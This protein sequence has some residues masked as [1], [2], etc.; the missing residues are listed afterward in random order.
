MRKH[1]ALFFLLLILITCTSCRAQTE[2]NTL[3]AFTMR[4]NQLSTT[5]TLSENGYI[6]DQK[7]GT[8]SRF[9]KFS[10]NEFLLQFAVDD[11][12]SLIEMSIVYTHTLSESTTEAEFIKN[13]ISAFINDPETES[14]LFKEKSLWD[15]LNATSLETTEIKSG[16]TQLLLDVTEYGTVITV[17]KNSPQA[18]EQEA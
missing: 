17:V 12:N 4:M 2:G 7:A 11:T 9:Y 15:L 14:G 8:L 1:F 18:F 3:Y 10:D 5:Y 6:L 13:C 16:D